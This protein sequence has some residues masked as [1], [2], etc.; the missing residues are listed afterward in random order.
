MKNS[1]KGLLSLGVIATLFFTSCAKEELVIPMAT[2]T[3]N[4]AEARVLAPN[5]YLSVK[6]GRTPI[7]ATQ[8]PIVIKQT[9]TFW[10]TAC[11]T[12]TILYEIR[13][14]AGTLLA[15]VPDTGVTTTVPM[16]NWGPF[17]VTY[18]VQAVSPVGSPLYTINL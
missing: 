8:T 15:T 16:P 2:N 18:T 3:P 12:Q 17:T 6:P 1:I 4:E 14:S 7:G 13:N 10:Q 5:M 9:E 11:L